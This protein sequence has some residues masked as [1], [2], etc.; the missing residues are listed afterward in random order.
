M[1]VHVQ[2]RSH[3]NVAVNGQSRLGV[4][5]NKHPR[6]IV[7]ANKPDT[8]F[9]R[10]DISPRLIYRFGPLLEAAR[11]I[12][13]YW[14]T[15]WNDALVSGYPTG[16]DAF[17]DYIV[18]SPLIDQLAEYSMNGY[19]IGHGQHDKSVHITDSDPGSSVTDN[20]IQLMLQNEIQLD[21]LPPFDQNTLYFVFLP[22]NTSI[23]MGGGASCLSFCGYHDHIN[24]QIFYAVMPFPNCPGCLSLGGNN[25]L[26]TA[27]TVVASHE[28]CEAITDPIPGQGWY[29]D[30]YGEIGDI[31]EEKGNIKQLSNYTVQLEWSN[32]QDKCV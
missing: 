6:R 16:L 17:F 25:D 19:T 5:V 26:F 14:G 29:D 24:G 9:R 20:D 2:K 27:L 7:L 15:E 30:T 12:T 21:N 10:A 1:A 4:S 28:L 11:V 3:R 32:Q 13:V 31:C 18:S 8:A 22:P 23:S